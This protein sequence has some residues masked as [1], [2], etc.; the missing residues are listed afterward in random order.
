M[1]EK[2]P[3]SHEVVYFQMLDFD[4]QNLILRSQNHIREKSLY[5]RGSCFSHCLYYMYQQLPIACYQVRFY[6]NQLV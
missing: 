1:E 3:L 6:A 5:F 2:T 4:P